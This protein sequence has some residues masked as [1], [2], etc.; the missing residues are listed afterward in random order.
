MG[1]G[2]ALREGH[3]DATLS[4]EGRAC[5]A[6]PLPGS[7]LGIVSGLVALAWGERG[8]TDVLGWLPGR[9]LVL[10]NA[11]NDPRQLRQL[12]AAADLSTFAGLVVLADDR[13]DPAQFGPIDADI[14]Q[15]LV[16]R[17][18]DRERILRAVRVSIDVGRDRPT[19]VPSVPA[20]RHERSRRMQVPMPSAV[21]GIVDLREGHRRSG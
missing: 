14:P 19:V 9:V 10:A 2:G 20:P 16:T 8:V 18:P 17:A 15:V 13:A 7:A 6:R 4:V 1:P 3:I 5:A 21:P 11:S 12:L